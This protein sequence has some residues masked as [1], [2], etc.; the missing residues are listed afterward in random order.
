MKGF[1]RAAVLCGWL[2]LAAAARAAAPEESAAAQQALSFRA[3]QADGLRRLAARIE[4]AHLSPDAT[5]GSVLERGGDGWIALR[6]FLRSA[7]PAGEPRYYSDGVTE[8]DLEVSLGLGDGWARAW[9]CDLTHG[10]VDENAAYY[11]S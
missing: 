6:L 10:Y 1:G 7:R 5:V 8:V 9:G 4:S 3:A 2:C 11:S